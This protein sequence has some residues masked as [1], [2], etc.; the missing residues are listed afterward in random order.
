MKKLLLILLITATSFG[1]N[2]PNVNNQPKTQKSHHIYDGSST[3][4][5]YLE[6]E[7]LSHPSFRL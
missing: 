7:Y 3:G 1:Q 5:W 6:C 2:I 4:Y